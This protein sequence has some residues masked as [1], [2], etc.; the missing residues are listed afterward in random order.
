[1]DMSRPTDAS[2]HVLLLTDASRRAM[3]LELQKLRADCSHQPD[4]AGL[5]PAPRAPQL[6][7][8]GRVDELEG[9]LR[10][11]VVSHPGPNGPEVVA[12][13]TLVDVL[14]RDVLCRYRLVMSH[15]RPRR[16]GTVE[17]H[18]DSTLGRR[19]LWQTVND[20]VTVADDWGK[21]P[22]LRIVR[23]TDP[24]ADLRTAFRSIG[25]CVTALLRRVPGG[26][27]AEM[28]ASSHGS[29]PSTTT[30]FRCAPNVAAREQGG[31]DDQ[32]QPRRGARRLGATPR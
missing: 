27:G 3:E 19:L 13:G 4:V 26:H 5:R 14:E 23:I 31:P 20:T 7:V 30:G 18:V 6:T 28:V 24:A 29:A 15:P 16:D 12:V 21:P 10:A 17:V 25:G 22:A 8:Q 32:G 2:E 11:A 9:T 1:M